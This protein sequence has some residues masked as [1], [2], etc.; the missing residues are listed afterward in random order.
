M[1]GELTP[2]EMER[3]QKNFTAEE[4]EQFMKYGNE[5]APPPPDKYD[6]WKFFREVKSLSGDDDFFEHLKIGNLNDDE[7][8]LMNHS[9]RRYA[10]LGAYA[11]VEGLDDVSDFLW[12]KAAFLTSTS[13]SR[14]GFLIQMA[15]TQKR[16]SKHLGAKRTTTKSGL[17]GDTTVVEGE[18]EEEKGDSS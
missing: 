16:V 4:L 9:V 14:K 15:I 3:L 10:D 8:G 17:F 6:L 18:D 2:E 13:L 7:L 5:T 1:T 12:N 11:H